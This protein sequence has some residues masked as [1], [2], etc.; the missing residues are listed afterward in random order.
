MLDFLPEILRMT[1]NFVCL[2]PRKKKQKKKNERSHFVK[3]SIPNL[4]NVIMLLFKLKEKCLAYD[5]LTLLSLQIITAMKGA[6]H[7]R[8]F[9]ILFTGHGCVFSL[10]N[11]RELL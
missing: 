5:F 3:A 1:S 11:V 2:L 7:L 9:N 8:H 4:L 10:R 6:F